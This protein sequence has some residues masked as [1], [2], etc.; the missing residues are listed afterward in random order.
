MI[1]GDKQVQALFLYLLVFK[2]TVFEVFGSE[3]RNDSNIYFAGTKYS[4]KKTEF[5]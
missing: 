3:P 1:N 4:L 2:L 5:Y